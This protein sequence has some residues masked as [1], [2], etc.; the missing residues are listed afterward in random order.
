M[1]HLVPRL[2][3]MTSPGPADAGALS[4][5]Y[6]VWQL[7][8]QVRCPRSA[9]LGHRNFVAERLLCSYKWALTQTDVI[10]S[11]PVPDS[12]RA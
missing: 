4:H 12:E 7:M 5:S 11:T 9:S 6:P 2:A 1:K 10:E 8:G 3:S